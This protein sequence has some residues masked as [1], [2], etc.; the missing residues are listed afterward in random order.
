MGEFKIW[1]EEEEKDNEYWVA[2][3]NL[4]VMKGKLEKL[5]R[6]AAKLGMPPVT[7]SVL[8][9][10]VVKEPGGPVEQSQIKLD[11]AAPKLK[12]W[13]FVARIMHGEGGNM[14]MNVPD[15]EIPTRYRT[16]PP[17]CDHC[18]SNRNRKDTFVLRSDSGEYKQVG[19]NC[20]R[21]FLGTEDPA[22]YVL[23]FSEL[24]EF[25][26]DMEGGFGG[27]RGASEIETLKFLAATIAV[28]RK[29]GFVGKKVAEE[30]DLPTTANRV[31]DYF[32]GTSK[33]LQ[34][35]QKEVDAV[36]KPEDEDKAEK[37]IAWA[38][39]LKD[40]GEDSLED[41]LWNLSVAAERLTVNMKL[42]GF[43]ASLPSAYDR[44]MG[45]SSAQTKREAL[46]APTLKAGDKFE[47]ILTVEK[48]RSWETQYGVTNLHIMKDD[49]G[50][51]YKWKASKEKIDEGSR[52]RIKG[53]VKGVE[54]DKYNNNIPTVELT[55]CKVLGMVMVSGDQEI[56]A[57]KTEL[58]SEWGKY[59][60]NLGAFFSN[61]PLS[62]EEVERYCL[63]YALPSVL[64]S[65]P[66]WERILSR[67]WQAAGG[68]G[69]SPYANF[70]DN[71]YKDLERLKLGGAVVNLIILAKDDVD[72]VKELSNIMARSH[73]GDVSVG[74]SPFI[75]RMKEV[76]KDLWKV[77]VAESRYKGR[78]IQK[79]WKCW[80]GD[81]G[82]S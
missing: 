62:D 13:T 70:K 74:D 43:M 81:R 77:H 3:R 46:P 82:A 8:G 53:S 51:V 63:E 78:E 23:Y 18:R 31:M 50:Q 16:A 73:R 55:R 67:A 33:E 1:L 4:D 2:S 14:V 80:L 21:D 7:M 60:G 58:A 71:F 56:I 27:G 66:E 41:Y 30:R 59:M 45:A 32:F 72:L 79:E 34:A 15:Q 10:R 22:M 28:V 35:F 6:R 44:A 54:P 48:V 9:R 11:G 26:D 20:L 64:Q 38:R 25:V 29:L 76:A 39:S 52:V 49:A 17:A 40:A 12:G 61:R 24:K 37:M 19:T 5:N 69:R 42:A 47:G 75:D 36:R 65:S 57:K 68:A